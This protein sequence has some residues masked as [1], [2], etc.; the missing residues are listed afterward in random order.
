MAAVEAK[1]AVSGGVAVRGRSVRDATFDLL[2]AHGMTTVFG[3]PGSTEMGFLRDFPADFRYVLALHEGVAVGMADGYAQASR[4]PAFVN[5]HSACGVGNA[6]GAVVNAFH[7]RAPLVITAGN[8]DRRHLASEPYLFARGRELMAPYVKRS[9]ETAR[10]ADVPAAIERAWQLARTPPCGPVFV[11]IPVDDWEA[12]AAPVRS[13]E[14][15]P[16]RRP[17]PAALDAL[18]ARVLNSERPV[19]IAGAGIDRDGAWPAVVALAEK[20]GTPVWAAPQ[21]PRAGF[22][23]DHALFRGHL[24]A[25]HAS[26]AA[27]LARADLALVLGAPAFAFLPYEPGGALPPLV[28]VTDDPDEAARGP[29]SS[30]RS[31]PTSARSPRAC[32]SGS[33]RAPRRGLSRDRR[34][35]RP[36]RPPRSPPPT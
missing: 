16:A 1:P 23:E 15:L 26:A 8:Q 18:A 29:P 6:M 19:L 35:S 12:E 21:A 11:S 32:T 25:G 7:D 3:N 28:Q 33:S 36:L 4:R 20:L 14:V 13:H 24:A 30:S 27:Q 34:R 2:R 10:A 5:L 31:W 17:D 9:E 22:P